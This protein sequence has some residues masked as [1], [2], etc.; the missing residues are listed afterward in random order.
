MEKQ[1]GSKKEK[2]YVK[3][4]NCHPADL[5][6]M[7]STSWE[8]LGWK[9]HKLESRLLGEISITSDMQMTP[10]LWQKVKKNK[11]ASWWQWKRR[12]KSWLKA[13]HS[14]NK[15][16]GIQPHHFMAN[17]WIKSGNSGRLYLWGTP[18]SLHV[19][20]QLPS[21][22]SHCFHCF[23]IYLPWSDGTR[24]HDLTFLNVEF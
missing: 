7:Q 19:I 5:T 6:Y 17:K 2:E 1:K 20:L 10:P 12:A 22:V 14:E 23:P 18:E 11:R 3:V 24:C 15:H 9:K 8:T 21:K 16:H 13:Q 4:V